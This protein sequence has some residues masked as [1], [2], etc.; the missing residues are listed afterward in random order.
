VC[1][2]AIV[3][4]LLIL[5][6]SLACE[7]ASSLFLSSPSQMPMLMKETRLTRQKSIAEICTRDRERER[8]RERIYMVR[9]EIERILTLRAKS[10]SSWAVRVQ[11]H[12]H[13]SIFPLSLSFVFF[14]CI[15]YALP[16]SSRAHQTDLLVIRSTKKSEKSTIWKTKLFYLSQQ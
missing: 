6:D 2:S 9:E 7:D 5:L 12:I 15:V 1:S 3:S 16:L 13:H 14:Y 8:E 11:R 10:R 4:S